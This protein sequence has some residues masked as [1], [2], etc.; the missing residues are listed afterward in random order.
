MKQLWAWAWAWTI[1]AHVA[2]WHQDENKTAFLVVVA[3]SGNNIYRNFEE[4]AVIYQMTHLL[5]L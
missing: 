5:M 3:H 1:V 4:T 2:P